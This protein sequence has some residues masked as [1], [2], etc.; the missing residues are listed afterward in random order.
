MISNLTI[1]KKEIKNQSCHYDQRLSEIK[2]RLDE[3]LESENKKLELNKED[4]VSSSGNDDLNNGFTSNNNDNRSKNMVVENDCVDVDN[5]TEIVERVEV[6]NEM[7]VCDESE[8]ES[9]KDLQ[10]EWMQGVDFSLNVVV[11]GE[12]MASREYLEDDMPA[13]KFPWV[14]CTLHRLSLIHI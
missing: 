3:K 14:F 13:N 6:D 7:F 12:E 2:T 11:G 8:R 5:D 1:L 4:R 9:R 10:V